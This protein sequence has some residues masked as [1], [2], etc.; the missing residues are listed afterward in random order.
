MV[1]VIELSWQTGPAAGYTDVFPVDEFSKDAIS[2]ERIHLVRGPRGAVYHAKYCL[3]LSGLDAR[4]DYR[5][6]TAF[7]KRHG[8]L[9]GVLE[10]RFTNVGADTSQKLGG[11][12]N[13]SRHPRQ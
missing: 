4:L 6:F 1:Q 8:M 3:E 11:M 12:A 10:F 7:N 5:A 9:I 13:R 2:A